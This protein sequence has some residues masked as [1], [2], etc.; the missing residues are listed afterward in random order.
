MIEFHVSRAMWSDAITLYA[1]TTIDGRAYPVVGIG[2]EIK[3]D[4][5]EG[6]EWPSFLT[7]PMLTNGGQ[8][9]FDALWA[10]GFRPAGGESG[11]AHVKALN[12]HLQD[13]RRLV[14]KKL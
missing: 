13:M 5:R 14:F 3:K 7:F 12:D 8:S 1:K 9:L 6:D 11:V 10:A 4:A 2:I